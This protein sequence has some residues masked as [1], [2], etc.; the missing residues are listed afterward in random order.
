MHELGGDA[1]D[2]GGGGAVEQH[3]R[4]VAPVVE[5]AVEHE[6]GHVGG[7]Q[8]HLAG[9]AEDPA[10]VLDHG[11]IGL[12][13]ADDF[14]RRIAPGGGEEM[15]H[16]GPFRVLQ[17]REDLFRRQRAG[18][19]SD[20]RIG[21]D[22]GLDLGEDLALERQVLG[23][24]LD[25]PVGIG[26]VGVVERAV[27]IGDHRLGVGLAHLAACDG[28]ARVFG[29]AQQ[30]A[31]DGLLRD[32][33]QIQ[34]QVRQRALEVITDVGT[35][36]AGADD[37]DGAG[38]GAGRSG[39]QRVGEGRGHGR[40][41]FVYAV[42][43]EIIQHYRR[44]HNCCAGMTKLAERRRVGRK[45][46]RWR[47][48]ESGQDDGLRASGCGFGRGVGRGRNPTRLSVSLTSAPARSCA[49]GCSACRRRG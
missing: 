48:A 25:H 21:A 38:Q 41:L 12:V 6:A 18:V 9:G 30:G 15:R 19:G 37:G 31:F 32:I 20:Q 13:P 44:S 29:K 11:R 46:R 34:L 28:L 45:S 3:R 2:F 17:L 22:H 42:Y 1:V 43:N 16:R 49:A 27:E 36:G 39:K 14:D 24:G 5:Y 33:D 7:H 26:D 47:H 8:R 23:R 40:I 4:L 10:Q 35:D